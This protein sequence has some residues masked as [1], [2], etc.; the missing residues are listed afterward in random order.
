[1]I[2]V[3]TNV[4]ARFVLADDA[5]QHRRAV[6]ALEADEDFFIPVTVLLELAWVLGARDSTRAEITSAL[7]KIV[8][9][10][11]AHAQHPEAVGR[12]LDWMDSGLDIADAFHLALSERADRFLSFDANLLRRAAR[13][14][15]RPAVASPV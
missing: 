3:D 9:L 12:A 7:R 1:V 15:A 14:G 8:G 11:R 10:P 5:G 4:L 13:L 2:S 6:A